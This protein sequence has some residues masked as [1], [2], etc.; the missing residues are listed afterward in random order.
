VEAN[1]ETRAAMERRLALEK[2][3]EKPFET[4][5]LDTID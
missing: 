2:L 4:V 5:R 3:D 1:A